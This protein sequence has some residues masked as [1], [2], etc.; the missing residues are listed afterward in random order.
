MTLFWMPPSGTAMEIERL[1]P[2]SSKKRLPWDIS[3]MTTIKG[4]R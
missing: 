4:S 2:E 3:R 1:W